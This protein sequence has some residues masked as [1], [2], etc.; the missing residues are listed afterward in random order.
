MFHSVGRPLKDADLVSDLLHFGG[1]FHP[2]RLEDY[3]MKKYGIRPD[4]VQS[5]AAYGWAYNDANWTWFKQFRLQQRKDLI[6]KSGSVVLDGGLSLANDAAVMNLSERRVA[7]LV[8]LFLGNQ[9]PSA[10]DKVDI[11]TEIETV[12]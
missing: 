6:A 5:V 7:F 9:V 3:L 1:D 10:W 2:L 11:G 8:I 12:L 4:R